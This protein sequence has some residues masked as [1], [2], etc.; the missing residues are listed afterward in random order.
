MARPIKNDGTLDHEVPPWSTAPIGGW[1]WELARPWASVSMSR[2]GDLVLSAPGVQPLT[3]EPQ[4]T[5]AAA[6]SI[7]DGARVEVRNVD[8]SVRT[9]DVVLDGRA[10]NAQSIELRDRWNSLWGRLLIAG[11]SLTVF[12]PDSKPRLVVT[13]VVAPWDPTVVPIFA[14]EGPALLVQLL[15]H[16]GHAVAAQPYYLA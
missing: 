9:F 11:H 7:K 15:D 6:P 10:D 1:N 3:W 14:G 5:I 16:T 13:P 8:G 4:V 2:G 12:D